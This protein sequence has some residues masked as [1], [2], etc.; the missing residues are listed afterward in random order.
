MGAARPSRGDLTELLGQIPEG[1]LFFFNPE[2]LEPQSPRH[3]LCPRP[4][5]TQTQLS[6]HCHPSV[7]HT[8]ALIQPYHTWR[9]REGDEGVPYHSLNPGGFVGLV[10]ASLQLTL[11]SPPTQGSPAR[12]TWRAGSDGPT[13]HAQG[14][15]GCGPLQFP[16]PGSGGPAGHPVGRGSVQTGPAGAPRPHPA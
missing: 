1:L 2:S 4:N 6:W 10:Q 8:H 9:G 3:M 11:P 13:L 14:S 16:E 5:P 7:V 12:Q 15:W